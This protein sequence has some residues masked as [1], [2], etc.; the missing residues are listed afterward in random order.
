MPRSRRTGATAD[1]W[2]GFVDAL[3]TLLLVIIFLLVFFMLAQFFLS[4]ALTGREE[5]VNRLTQQ[6][7]EI[8]EL[9][10]LERDANEELKLTV[11]QLSSQLESSTAE[12]D[13]LSTRLAEADAAMAELERRLD[14]AQQERAELTARRDELQQQLAEA[15]SARSGL[16]SQLTEAQSALA[17]NREARASLEG[18]LEQS[19]ASAAELE[20][21]LAEL[22]QRMAAVSRRLAESQTQVE[23]R[24]RQ[25]AEVQ[26][27][28]SAEQ[29]VSAEAQ[30]QVDLLNQQ[31]ASLRDELKRLNA[32]LDAAD[33]KAEEQDA[34]IADLGRRLNRALAAKVEELSRYRSEFFGRLREV[35][36]SRSD[37]QIVGDRFVFQSEVLFDSG[38]AQ[39]NPDGREELA[40]LAREL[41]DIAKQIPADVDWILQ[42]NG[43]TDVQPIQTREF[44]SNWELS[45]ARAISVVKYLIS[46]GVP[47]ERLAAA[48]YAQ[49][50]PIDARR[51]EIAYRRNRRIEMKLTNR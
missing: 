31:I 11:S 23:T 17:E 35:L 30:R 24:D 32:A 19:R 38:S 18:E 16:E 7:N 39:I 34:L 8:T 44:P 4:Q 26:Q 10:S 21:R 28:L 25:L 33:A 29:D 27:K 43:H 9:L 2:P 49:Y 3:S 42:V 51:D 37:I 40:T 12:R 15:Q 20:Q 46:R 13:S 6:L 41:I 5:R 48:G 1:I 47:A 36:S 22:E 14:L 50:Q 45:S